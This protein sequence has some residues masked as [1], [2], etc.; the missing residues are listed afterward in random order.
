MF[1]VGSVLQIVDV[2]EKS[3]TG[4]VA[5]WASRVN[6]EEHSLKAE[7]LEKCHVIRGLDPGHVHHGLINV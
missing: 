2:F 3:L 5:V 1:K 6:P 7:K 4:G